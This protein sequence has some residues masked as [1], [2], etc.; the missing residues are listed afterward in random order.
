M[1]IDNVFINE[2][3]NVHVS[4]GSRPIGPETVVSL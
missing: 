1:Y 3:N 4:T 2:V